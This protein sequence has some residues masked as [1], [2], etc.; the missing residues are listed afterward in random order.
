MRKTTEAVRGTQTRRT[1]FNVTHIRDFDEDDEECE[2]VVVFTEDVEFTDVPKSMQ[3]AGASF[4]SAEEVHATVK[5]DQASRRGS[6]KRFLKLI[7]A[8]VVFAT[9]V[10]GLAVGVSGSKGGSN[11]ASSGVSGGGTGND[12]QPSSTGFNDLGD[13]KLIGVPKDTPTVSVPE[14]NPVVPQD[15]PV[16]TID[17][18]VRLSTVEEVVSYMAE[19]DVSY[20]NDLR[21]VGSP[22]NLAANWMAETDGANLEIPTVGTSTLNGYKYMVRYVMAVVFFSTGGVNWK[23]NLGFMTKKNVCDWNAY[24][25]LDGGQSYFRKGVVCEQKAN[26]MAALLLSKWIQCEE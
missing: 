13:Q 23:N 7:F 9:V 26:L 5:M 14:N 22:Q 15:N 4:P 11:E 24:Y 2:E 17:Q 21:A 20:L 19:Y 3:S 10:I 12:G 18:Y 1:M 25:S 6:D 8:A 16:V